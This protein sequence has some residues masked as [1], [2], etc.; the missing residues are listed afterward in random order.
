MNSS[1]SQEQLKELLKT[2]LVEVLQERKD[3]LRELIEE[4]LE[5]FMLTRAIAEGECSPT[6]HRDEVFQFLEGQE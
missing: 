6:I 2:A 1:L 4:A 3:L 5:D